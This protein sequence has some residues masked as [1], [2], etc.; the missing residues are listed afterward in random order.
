VA[1]GTFAVLTESLATAS[2]L[3]V[4]PFGNASTTGIVNRDPVD[5]SHW[6]SW[7]NNATGECRFNRIGDSA[8]VDNIF[9]MAGFGGNDTL[10]V[11][12]GNRSFCGYPTAPPNYGGFFLNLYGSDGNDNLQSGY[13]DTSIAGG[14]GN[15]VIFSGR[16]SAYHYGEDGNDTIVLTSFPTGSGGAIYGGNGNDCLSVSISSVTSSCGPGVDQWSGPGGVGSKPTSCE[17]YSTACCPL[18]ICWVMTTGSGPMNRYRAP[19]VRRLH[20]P[21]GHPRTKGGEEAW[22]PSN[23]REGR[24]MQARGWWSIVS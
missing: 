2:M 11:E 7:R 18:L 5:G 10:I 19:S 21:V 20:A 23:R 17:T 16:G 3:V 4:E 24:T 6:V 12:T 22:A 1:A 14:A 15:D 8:L 9:L 13:G